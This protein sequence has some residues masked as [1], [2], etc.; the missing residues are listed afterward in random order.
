MKCAAV[1]VDAGQLAH[2]RKCFQP[3]NRGKGAAGSTTVLHCII[4]PGIKANGA[5]QYQ[6]AENPFN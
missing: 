3:K 4:L 2:A 6:A 1:L 5:G